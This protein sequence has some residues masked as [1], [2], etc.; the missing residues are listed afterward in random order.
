MQVDDYAMVG[1]CVMS[2]IGVALAPRLAL[3]RLPDG[4]V[5]TE[6][7]GVAI[8]REVSALVLGDGSHLASGHLMTYLRNVDG[9]V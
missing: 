9:K 5:V 7:E 8:S 3:P 4:V 6:L 2:E 1:G